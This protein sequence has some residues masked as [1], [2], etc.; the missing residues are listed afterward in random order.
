MIVGLER[1][2]NMDEGEIVE[3]QNSYLEKISSKDC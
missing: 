1:Y 2:E 3:L